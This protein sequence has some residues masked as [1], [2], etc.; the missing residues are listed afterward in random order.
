MSPRQISGTL[1]TW[2]KRKSKTT[3]RPVLWGLGRWTSLGIQANYAQVLPRAIMLEG[4]PKTTP[5]MAPDT[6]RP[7][8]PLRVTYKW[9]RNGRETEGC[10]PYEERQTWRLECG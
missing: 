8:E 3:T 9:W 7:Q 6:Q 5:E 4:A 2:T 1:A 10:G